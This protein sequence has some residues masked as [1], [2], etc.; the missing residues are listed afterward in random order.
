MCGLGK[1]DMPCRDETGFS[2]SPLSLA[3]G[4]FLVGQTNKAKEKNLFLG[5][6]YFE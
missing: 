4:R 6:K 5:Q 1:G 2:A 3:I